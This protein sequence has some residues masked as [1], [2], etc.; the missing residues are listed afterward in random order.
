MGGLL[1]VSVGISF[2]VVKSGS[3]WLFEPFL[4]ASMKGLDT[5]GGWTKTSP[6]LKLSEY[7]SGSIVVIGDSV[8]V[9]L[10]SVEFRGCGVQPVVGK[11]HDGKLGRV[12]TGFNVIGSENRIICDINETSMVFLVSK[13]FQKNYYFLVKMEQTKISRHCDEKTLFTFI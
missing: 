13:G 6:G 8:V 9:S 4:M 7:E 11:V 3:M 2:S 1:V 10:K 12:V 5:T